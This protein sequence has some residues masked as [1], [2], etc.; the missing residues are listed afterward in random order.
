MR[1]E[2]DPPPHFRRIDIHH[3]RQIAADPAVLVVDVRDARAF[4]AGRIGS[5]IHVMS[6][7]VGRV[8]AQTPRRTP[9]L[10]YCYHGHSSQ[11]YAQTFADFGFRE[12]YS[13][14]G[15]YEAW[16]A[17]EPDATTTGTGR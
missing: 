9:I 5:A 8:I 10:V 2:T 1:P 6:A 7:N 11:T 3:A 15:G 13:M 14:D 17:A 4:A 16:R 12:V